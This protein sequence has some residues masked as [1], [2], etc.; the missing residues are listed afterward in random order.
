MTARRLTLSCLAFVVSL[1]AVSAARAEWPTCT[2]LGS[3]MDKA[4]QKGMPICIL[5]MEFS[6]GSSFG[7]QRIGTYESFPQYQDM[8]AV[9]VPDSMRDNTF[10]DITNNI[11]N[12]AW[13]RIIMIDG[14]GRVL[15]IQN[16][17]QSVDARQM[18]DQANN[19]WQITKWEKITDDQLK[20]IEAKIAHRQFAELDAMIK[21]IY[22]TDK[23]I[24]AKL[25]ASVPWLP[26]MIETKSRIHR[27]PPPPD[28]AS[29][30]DPQARKEAER[31][32]KRAEEAKQKQA[33]ATERNEQWFFYSE[34]KDAR[35]KLQTAVQTELAA[36]QELYDAGKLPE[37]QK[38]LRLIAFYKADDDLAKNIADL[39][40]QVD[41]A[42]KTGVKPP[43]RSA[44]SAASAAKAVKAAAA[45]SAAPAAK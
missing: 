15:G 40:T 10:S 35:A 42:V 27:D 14:G 39:K 36:D 44:T 22:D 11:N 31:A 6:S 23:K 33:E 34:I 16:E 9:R 20:T 8:L 37:A 43:P 29:I 25:K 4:K 38:A 13:P 30:E 17:D 18:A 1:A 19:A 3:L 12:T 5:R 26:E 24:S 21:N 41:K 7:W 45:I 2:D 28:P 32:L